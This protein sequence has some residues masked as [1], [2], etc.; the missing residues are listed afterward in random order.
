MKT[1]FFQLT[2]L[3]ASS[4]FFMSATQCAQATDEKRA[5][6]KNVKLMQLHASSFLDNGGFSFSEVARSQFSG[7]LFEKDYFF[8][9]NV[10]PTIDDTVIPD[11]RYFDVKA[12]A[13]EKVVLSPIVKQ[14]KKW[15]PQAKS[16]DLKFS[17]NS[18]CLISRPQHFIAGKINALEAHSG[19]ALQFGFNQSLVQLPVEAKFKLDKMRMDLSFHAFNPWTQQVVSSVNAEAFKSDYKASFGIDLGIIHI[20]PEFYRITGMAEVTLKGLQ[21]SI[22]AL[23]KKLLAANGE[24]WSSR[25]IYSGDNN[26]VILGGKELGLKSGDQLKVYN[27]IHTWNGESCGESSVLTGSTI[28]SDTK[29]PW[30]IEI[31]DAGDLMSSARVL[32]I[33]E[34]TSIDLGALVKVHMFT[35]QVKAA[36]AGAAASKKK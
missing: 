36:A 28:V 33:K 15:F 19:G 11:Q 2:V 18:A 3:I 25:I 29:D 9:R 16:Q 17:R 22:T 30:I 5:L 32:N 12:A 26:V 13:G 21:N 7:V 31:L 8:E 23:A 6:K 1:Q 4:I 34:D 24:E 14:I 27:Q 35:E 10:Y 20:G